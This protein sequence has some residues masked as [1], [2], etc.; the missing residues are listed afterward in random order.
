MFVIYKC[1]TTLYKYAG[2]TITSHEGIKKAKSITPLLFNIP[3]LFT[4]MDM[5]NLQ[6]AT[7]AKFDR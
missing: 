6:Y 1:I 4:Q 7:V 5:L 3:L 2:Y